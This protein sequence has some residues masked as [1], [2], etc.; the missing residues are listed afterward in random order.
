MLDFHPLFGMSD[1]SVQDINQDCF[2]DFIV[3][4]GDNADLSPI[5][6][7]YHGIRIFYGDGSRAVT[8]G[9]FYPMPGDMPIINEDFDQDGLI[10]IAAVSYFPDFSQKERLDWLYFDNIESSNPEV[11]RLQVSIKSNWLT[12]SRRDFDQDGDLDIITFSSVF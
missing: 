1:L 5:L 12:L 10:E 7:P 6:K 8:K 11:F 4:N 3:S 9:W 2:E